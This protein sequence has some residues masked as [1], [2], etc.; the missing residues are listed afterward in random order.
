MRIAQGLDGLKS[1]PAGGVL[2]IGNFDGMHRGHQEI[3]RI[4]RELRGR[5]PGRNLTVA[6]F[7][8]H[9]FTV[10]RPHAVPPR[11]TTAAMKE[12]LLRR[13]D[14]D[15]LVVLPPEPAVLNVTAEEFWAI[16]R[17]HARPSHIVEGSD[18][19]FGKGRGGT[20]QKLRDWAG[21][22]P[23]QLTIVEPVLVVL[24]DKSLVP[25]S[26]TLVRWLVANGRMRDAAICLARP[27]ALEGQVVQGHQRGRTIGFPTANLN[28][29][30]QLIP[31]DGVYA[32]RCQVDNLTYPAAVSIGAMP[33]FGENRRQVEAHFPGLPDRDLYGKT[34]RLELLD[35]FRDQWKFPNVD[36]LKARLGKDVQE[37]IQRYSVATP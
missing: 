33:T 22:S 8:P 16:L 30:Q 34:L 35:W 29:D 37:I 15:V 1:L 2:S 12:E 17:D 27:Y 23:I 6:T 10:L 19:S 26:S 13:Q 3:L 11:L 36:M 24:S 18:F 5:Q 32:G 20:I 9:P 21:P 7:E 28:C 14:V 4:A 31:A 25:V